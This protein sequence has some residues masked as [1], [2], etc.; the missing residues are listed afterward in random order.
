MKVIYRAFLLAVVIVCIVNFIYVTDVS[1][2]T[3]AR[4]TVTCTSGKVRSDAST[5]SSVVFC[6]T[7]DEPLIIID[8]KK[9][10]GG[11]VWYQVKSGTLTGYIRSD[12]V[13]KGT[14]IPSTGATNSTTSAIAGTTPTAGT[15]SSTGKATV[16]GTNVI[17]RVEAS[18]TSDVRCN[19]WYRT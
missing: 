9:D 1:A 19:T 16:K 2:Y 12:L 15:A 5:T 6:V 8:E 13:K 7:K 3:S 17:V 10:A 4:G 18:R 14:E 11:S